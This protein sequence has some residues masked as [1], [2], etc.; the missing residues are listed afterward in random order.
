MSSSDIIIGYSKNDFFYVNAENNETMPTAE[1]CT[2]LKTHDIS[3]DISCNTA[4]F[5]DSSANCL[6]KELCINKDYS[7]KIK[8][9]Q[10]TNSGSGEKYDNAKD[11]YDQ[12][13]IFVVVHGFNTLNGAL[14][15][16]DM[17]KSNKQ[18]IDKEY[19]SISSP[20]YQIIQIHKNLEEYLKYQ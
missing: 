6:K 7:N 10:Q 5:I 14:G 1:M 4:N 16:S 20:N 18:Q 11:V 17:L 3:W 8:S 12:N 19:F 2:D 13:T 15:F 9:M